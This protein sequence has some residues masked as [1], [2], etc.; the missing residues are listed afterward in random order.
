MS[1][2]ILNQIDIKPLL[3]SKKRLDD[4]ISEAES[5][6]EKTGAIKTFEYCYEI[7]W[8]LMKKILFVKGIDESTPRD[9]F[10]EAAKAKII[11]NP[12][13]WF[14]FIKK[15]NLTAHTY[16]NNLAN[17]VLEA[18]PIFQK[19]LDKFIKTIKEL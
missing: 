15:R 6:L 9:I 2:Y 7:A 8:K 1:D 16:D 17:E 3:D 13:I 5:E 12:E 10:R 19:E 4:A 18:L 11:D 14:E